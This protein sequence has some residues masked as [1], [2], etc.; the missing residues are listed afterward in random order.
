[1]LRRHRGAMGLRQQICSP[2]QPHE[3]QALWC[4]ILLE[5]LDAR[6]IQKQLS[7]Q[8]RYTL[9]SWQ[10]RVC[11]GKVSIGSLRNSRADAGS[12]EKTVAC[13]T[14]DRRRAWVHVRT[15]R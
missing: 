6:G 12:R 3:K 5:T 7:V 8:K 2:S 13:C 14:L 10:V 9:H 1:M 4:H 15:R 11:Y